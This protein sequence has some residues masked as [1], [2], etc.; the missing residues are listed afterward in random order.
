MKT[1][2][3]MPVPGITELTQNAA[4]WMQQELA[5]SAQAGST[6]AMS[7]SDLE[8][9]RSNIQA[10]AFAQGLSLHGAYRFLRDF[11]ARQAVPIWSSGQILDGW[12]ESYKMKRKRASAATGAA[13]GTGVNGALLLARTVLQSELGHR[14]VVQADAT[15]IAGVINVSLQAELPG[16]NSNVAA[17]AVLKL[18]SSEPDVDST[19]IVGSAGLA[20]GTND[21]SDAQALYRLQQRIANP[22][23]GGCPGDYARWALEVPGITR[24]WGLRN[25][26]GPTSAGV[27]IMADDNTD[28]HG[29]PS[30]SQQQAVYDYI[31]DPK[32]GPPDEL[33]V[34]VPTLTLVEP[35]IMLTPDTSE[36]RAGTLAALSDLFLREAVPGGEIP[37]SHLFDVVSDVVGEYNHAFVSPAMS[38]GGVFSTPGFAHLLALGDVMFGGV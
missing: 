10:L 14:Y 27:I 23:M 25:P 12:L 9:A 4:R 8:L 30:E 19:F 35:H 26:V 21:E 6:Q 38:S 17:G 28:M 2:I 18:V 13:S 11:I 7:T 31:R 37:H 33:F 20:N 22:P 32:R 5:A 1:P 3:N 24:A 29:L 34:I 15:V 36:T 16:A